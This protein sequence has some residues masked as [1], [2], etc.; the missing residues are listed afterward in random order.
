LLVVEAQNTI[1]TMR[2]KLWG[3]VLNHRFD[4]NFEKTQLK[5]PLVEFF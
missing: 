3:V 2:V 4:G 5:S 1:Q